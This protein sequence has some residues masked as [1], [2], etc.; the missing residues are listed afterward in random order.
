[1]KEYF[2]Y[3][4][5]VDGKYVGWYVDEESAKGFL[6]TTPNATYK[7]VCVLLVNNSV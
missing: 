6:M 4:I 1:M 5:S 7:G 2:V 3:E